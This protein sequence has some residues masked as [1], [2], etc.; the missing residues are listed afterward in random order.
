MTKWKSPEAKSEESWSFEQN[1]IWESPTTFPVSGSRQIT[2][3]SL[4]FSDHERSHEPSIKEVLGIH[5]Q[6][7]LSP[8]WSSTPVHFHHFNFGNI[9]GCRTVVKDSTTTR[10]LIGPLNFG[11]IAA[12][13]SSSNGM[14]PVA[15]ATISTNTVL[16]L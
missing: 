2:V 9:T 16:V 4:S 7:P 5:P 12:R 10:T 14:I 3:R 8:P 11:T 15:K 6:C 13:K 1:W